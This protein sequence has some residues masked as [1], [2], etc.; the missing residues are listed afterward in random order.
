M[1]LLD[2]FFFKKQI[3]AQ[4]PI[5]YKNIIKVMYIID[6]TTILDQIEDNKKHKNLQKKV[7]YQ[8]QPKATVL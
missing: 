1:L 5:I 7:L 3:V 2:L 6:P 4:C 8:F